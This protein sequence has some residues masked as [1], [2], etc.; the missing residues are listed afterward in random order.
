MWLTI[1]SAI[2]S[3]MPIAQK[4]GVLWQSSAGFTKIA[5]QVVTAAPAAIKAIDEWAAQQFPAIEAGAR[6]VLG[7]LHMW[8]PESTKWVQR[9]LNAA[10]IMGLIKF[11]DPL[12]EDGIFG[13]KTFAAVVVLQ[14][15]LGLKITGAVTDAEY[16]ALNLVLEGKTP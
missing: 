1:I 8:V 14:A 3:F 16:K 7:A 5:E 10:Q 11:G 9:A 13:N 6:R 12:V 4:I 15:K 2:T